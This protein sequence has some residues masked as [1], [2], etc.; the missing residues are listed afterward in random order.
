MDSR[1]TDHYAYET[2]FL[3]RLVARAHRRLEA[4]LM[5]KARQAKLIY[6][7]QPRFAVIEDTVNKL[8]NDGELVAVHTPDNVTYLVTPGL[9]E[10]YKETG[11]L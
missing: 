3:D 10:K 2:I 6:R 8:M 1:L 5:R 4:H 7:N 9:K 11:C